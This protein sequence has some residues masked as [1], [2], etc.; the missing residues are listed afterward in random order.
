M[1]TKD[2]SAPA[3]ITITNIDP[4]VIDK[5]NTK[6]VDA[7]VVV[8]YTTPPMPQEVQLYRV[9]FWVSIPVGDSLKIVA[10]T[11]EE[12]AYYAAMNSERLQV[13]TEEADPTYT[14]TYDKGTAASGSAPADA[15]SPYKKDATVTVLGNTGSLVGPEGTT[16]F[17]GWNTKA[18]G[19]GTSYS[20][21]DTFVITADTVLYAQFTA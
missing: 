4:G 7:A 17:A 19:T 1:A 10:Q 6:V 15:N 12:V 20:A 9:N 11:S 14:V 5:E 21:S 18:D 8:A 3:V 13:V 16:T 2:Y